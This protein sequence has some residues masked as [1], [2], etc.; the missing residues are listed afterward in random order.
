[1]AAAAST[2]ERYI[3]V[4]VTVG[5]IA[6][7]VPCESAECPLALALRRTYAGAQVGEEGWQ[8]GLGDTSALPPDAIMFVADFDAGRPVKPG[9]FR[10]FLS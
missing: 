4:E 9:T 3:D 8:T 10:L 1:M 2:P 6:E 7:G 5:D